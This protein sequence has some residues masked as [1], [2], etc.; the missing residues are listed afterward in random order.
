M[1]GV[2][3]PFTVAELQEAARLEDR[4]QADF[5]IAWLSTQGYLEKETLPPQ[6]KRGIKRYRLTTKE[7]KRQELAEDVARTQIR[8]R[9][10]V[11]LSM[12]QSKWRIVRLNAP[13]A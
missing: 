10:S 2:D 8:P 3:H 9:P 6:G 7:E 5:Q 11:A 4:S 1:R 12:P 13:V